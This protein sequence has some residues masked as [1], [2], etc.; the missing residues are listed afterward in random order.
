V[1]DRI[2]GPAASKTTIGKFLL[3]L[4]AVGLTI[5]LTACGGET[6]TEYSEA[7]QEAFLAACVDDAV[8]GV[9]QQRVCRCVYDEARDAI[10]F[11]RFLEINEALTDSEDAVLPDDLLDVVAACVIEEGDL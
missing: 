1:S 5:G 7:N 4:A 2:L 10:A 8:D 11:E 9:Y 6:P 3:F